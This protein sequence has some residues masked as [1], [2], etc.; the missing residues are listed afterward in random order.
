MIALLWLL[1]LLLHIFKPKRNTAYEFTELL[2][3]L[4]YVLAANEDG[5]TILS[6]KENACTVHYR[7]SCILPCA[8][9]FQ[10]KPQ[11]EEN[12]EEKG[13][14]EKESSGLTYVRRTFPHIEKIF[15]KTQLTLDRFLCKKKFL[16]TLK[17]LRFIWKISKRYTRQS[18]FGA[19][20][21]NRVDQFFM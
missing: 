5:K 11:S 2:I 1:L 16:R 18:I 8:S 3:F 14:I 4:L 12:P 21:I 6:T 13:K 20:E 19:N 17:K 9:G 7:C 10:G 15:E